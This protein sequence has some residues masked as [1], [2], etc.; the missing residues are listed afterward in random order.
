MFIR[1][2][3]NEM[4]RWQFNR[5]QNSG[6]DER[7]SKYQ[8]TKNAK[9]NAHSDLQTLHEVIKVDHEQDGFNGRIC[10]EYIHV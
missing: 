5:N 4:K 3:C 9:H 7:C 2:N 8:N 10:I 6:S 1:V